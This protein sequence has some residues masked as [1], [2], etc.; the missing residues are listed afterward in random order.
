MRN[1]NLFI[2]RTAGS[3]REA[4]QSPCSGTITPDVAS[5]TARIWKYAAM[6]LMVLTL[7]V[8]QMWG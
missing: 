7:G 3:V 4:Q 2:N 1:L 6:V 8:G 5:I